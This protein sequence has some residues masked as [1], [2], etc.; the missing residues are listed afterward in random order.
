MS[1]PGER[2]CAQVLVNGLEDQ[3]CPG[4]LW[5]GKLTAIDM[6]QMCWLDSKTLI[7]QLAALGAVWSGSTL[8]AEANLYV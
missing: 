1:I 6:T 5:L 3:A 8:F 2:R 4:K 7:N